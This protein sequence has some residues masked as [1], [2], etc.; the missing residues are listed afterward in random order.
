MRRCRR[1]G[2]KNGDTSIRSEVQ[3]YGGL[4]HAAAVIPRLDKSVIGSGSE[5][6]ENF[7][8]SAG[9]RVSGDAVGSV[10]THGGDALGTCWTGGIGFVE[11]RRADGCAGLG[12]N[13]GDGWRSVGRY[14]QD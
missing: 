12:G 7:Q 6:E 10:D 1:V 8:V 5:L 13:H 4:A 9:D 3:G 14:S 11:N 2:Q